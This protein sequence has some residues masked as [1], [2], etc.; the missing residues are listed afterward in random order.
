[1]NSYTIG[2]T[3]K[4]K[5][6][7]KKNGVLYNPETVQATFIR[8]D[9]TE[10]T[11]NFAGVSPRDGQ[12]TRI[13]TGIYEYWYKYTMVGKWRINDRWTDQGGAAIV[14]GRAIDLEITA[15]PFGWVDAP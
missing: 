9:G 2:Y 7:C 12:L 15:D 10:D 4:F 1:M 6:T 3:D 8:P 13:S 11:L 5:I 14:L